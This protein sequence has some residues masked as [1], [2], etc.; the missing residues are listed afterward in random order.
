M[1]P[2][3]FRRRI[4]KA[5]K[6]S[7]LIMLILLL[8][9]VLTYFSA[10]ESVKA[11]G[12]TYYIK[13]DGSI[14]P[15]TALIV[16]NGDLYTFVGN[17][18]G[19]IVI[20]KDN[21]KI[22]GAGYALEGP[23]EIG[24]NLTLRTN[25][26]INNTIIKTFD[27]GVFLNSSN[28]NSIVECYVTEC[29]EG[30]WLEESSYNNIIS[31]NK[32]TRNSFDGIYLSYSSGNSILENEIT[33]NIGDGIQI[34]SSSNNRAFANNIINNR[35]GVESYYS[36]DNLIFHNNFLNNTDQAHTGS[37]VDIWDKGYPSGGNYWSN[38]AGADANNDG[39]GDTPYVIDTNNKD[40]YPL[41]Q[42]WVPP[43]TAVT[44]LSPYKA[45]F[46]EGYPL[47]INVSV[48][49]RGNKIEGFNVTLY[50]NTTLIRREYLVLN[51]DNSTTI[52]L[53]W[54]TVGLAEYKNYIISAYVGPLQ[55]ETHL[56][57]NTL[58]YSPLTTVHKGDVNGDKKVNLVDVFAVALAF[59][60]SPPDPRYNP[61]LDI[62]NDGKINLIDY[63]VT[64]L[65]FGWQL[66]LA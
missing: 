61:N 54:N 51:K 29:L 49:N 48:T 52:T 44:H 25:V 33:L 30:I 17:I 37:S 3:H 22:D 1:I 42:P 59:G 18:S 11:Y 31:E 34:Q 5:V 13:A 26:T 27:Y 14:F 60:S 23:S 10:I 39:L 15:S 35:W 12:T 8:I 24:M 43:D 20:E 32:V 28:N 63:F 4:G 40:N 38:Y 62:N 66:Q 53:S 21:V 19:T 46:T 16:R 6:P 58:S 9:S 50:A 55:G 65:N 45:L 64:T 56:S 2:R 47:P 7:S 57:D 36:S 41:M